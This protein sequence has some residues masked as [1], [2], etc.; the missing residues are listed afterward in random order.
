MLNFAV[1][2]SINDLNNFNSLSKIIIF[3][4]SWAVIWLPI[5][6]PIL[7]F[8]VWQKSAPN[9]NTHKLTLILSLYSIAPIL[10]WGVL[11]VENASWQEIGII[12][13]A[14]LFQSIL[15]GYC[16]SIATLFL[17]YGI[18][19]AL[20]WL[21]WQQKPVLNGDFGITLIALVLVSLIIGSIEEL[22]FRGV[23][24]NFLSVDYAL[25]LTVHGD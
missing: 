17:V 20:G 6:L 16:L 12:W 9:P 24:V 21:R 10:V 2:F 18:Q 5:V 3:L 13:Q 19:L 23:I 1:D 11:K 14:S 15:F 22:I 4:I 8:T 25:W 7:W